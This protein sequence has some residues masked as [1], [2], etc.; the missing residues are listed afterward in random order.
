MADATSPDREGDSDELDDCVPR[1]HSLLQR[2][3]MTL[4]S[5]L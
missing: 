3:R 2:M 4:H 5:Y 1:T